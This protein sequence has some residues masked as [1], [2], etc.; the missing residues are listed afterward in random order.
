MNQFLVYIVETNQ[1]EIWDNGYNIS[2]E[3]IQALLSIC[4]IQN[5]TLEYIGE[6]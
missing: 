1:V 4:S 3:A 2:P 5:Y 6:L